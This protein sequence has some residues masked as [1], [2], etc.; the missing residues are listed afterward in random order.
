MNV[1]FEKTPLVPAVVQDAH[2]GE[3]RMLGYMDRAALDATRATGELHLHSRS[4]GKLWKKGETSGNIHKVV[5]VSIDCDGDA[6][7]VTVVPLCP[8]CHAGTESCFEGPP[9][10]IARL[11]RVIRSRIAERPGG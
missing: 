2:T 9:P 3:V 6:I 10:T 5:G 11:E 4:R 7:L 8:T 1:D